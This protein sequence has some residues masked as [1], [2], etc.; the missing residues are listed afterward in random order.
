VPGVIYA[1]TTTPHDPGFGYLDR[2][3]AALL[4]SVGEQS[5]PAVLWR[6]RYQQRTTKSQRSV[7]VNDGIILLPA[8]SQDL[9]LDDYITTEIRSA[10]SKITGEAEDSFMKFDAREGLE[11]EDTFG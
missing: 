9:A 1:S 11:D 4:E 3:V 8:L 5:V 10:C 7:V 6:L 2:A